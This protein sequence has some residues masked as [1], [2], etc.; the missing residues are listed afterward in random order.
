MDELC[1]ALEAK[2]NSLEELQQS[3]LKKEQVLLEFYIFLLND[4]CNAY[5]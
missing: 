2:D 1:R 5:V 3:L 4:D